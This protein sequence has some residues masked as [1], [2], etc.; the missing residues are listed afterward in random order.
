MM[1]YMGSMGMILWLVTIAL[2][3]V[4]AMAIFR[5]GSKSG[6]NIY[7][8][9]I[10]TKSGGQHAIDIAKERLAKGE[11]TFEEYDRLIQKLKEE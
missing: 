11:I 7:N 2:I 10:E 1:N 4:G 6:G 5:T 9:L 3:I 8:D